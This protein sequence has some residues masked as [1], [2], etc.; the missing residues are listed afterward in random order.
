MNQEEKLKQLCD[1]LEDMFEFLPDP[2]QYPSTFKFYL[3]MYEFFD[4]I[5]NNQE[6]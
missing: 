1:K 3:Q 6:R 4:K 2:L 5:K